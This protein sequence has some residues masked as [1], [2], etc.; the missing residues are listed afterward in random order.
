LE[1]PRRIS[2]T[3]FFLFSSK[4]LKPTNL[5][6][7]AASGVVNPGLGTIMLGITATS[8]SSLLIEANGEG[9]LTRPR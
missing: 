7:P 1:D 6:A 5:N 4:S 2:A 9:R 8:F 3:L